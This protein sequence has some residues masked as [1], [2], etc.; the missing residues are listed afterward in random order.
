LFRSHAGPGGHEAAQAADS[1]AVEAALR[2][3]A[4]AD[5]ELVEVRQRGVLERRAEVVVGLIHDPSRGSLGRLTCR[6]LRGSMPGMMLSSKKSS[7]EEPAA[8]IVVGDE[9]RSTP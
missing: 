8:W 5:R 4:W 1:A 2:R 6:F 7:L 3:S 9:L